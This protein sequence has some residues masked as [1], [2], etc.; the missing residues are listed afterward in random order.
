LRR[1]TIRAFLAEHLELQGADL[2]TLVEAAM[3][4]LLLWAL[5]WHL[6]A[7]QERP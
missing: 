3:E 4:D 7:L 2:E 1:D 5:D 6:T